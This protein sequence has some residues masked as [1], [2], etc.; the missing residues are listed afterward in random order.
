MKAKYR[1]KPMFRRKIRVRTPSRSHES[2]L[3]DFSRASTA[4]LELGNHPLTQVEQ[5]VLLRNY[6]VRIKAAFDE[7]KFVVQQFVGQLSSSGFACKIQDIVRSKLGIE[8]SS[9]VLSQFEQYSFD[10][11]R[12][13]C[14]CVFAQFMAMSEEFFEQDPL[15][16][17]N[18][19][20]AENMFR[21]AGF[22]AV[23]IAPCADGR[24]AHLISYV[25]RLPY[26]L[27]RRKAHAGAL[28]DVSESV[29]NWVFIEHSRFREGVPNSIDEPTRYL[30]IAV[31][32][33]SKSDPSHQ[34][35]AAHGSDDSKAAEAALSKL[36]DFR[37]AI[38]NRFGCGSTVQTLLI[39]MN[40]DDDSLKMHV[41]DK[42]GKVS[43]SRFVE[44]NA[45]F[46]QTIKMTA[47][48]ARVQ[49][50]QAVLQCNIKNGSTVALELMNEL[51]AWFIENNF[52][53]IEYVNQYEKGCY[54]DI[55]H[56][57]RFIGIGSGFEEVQIRNLTYYSYLDTVEEGFNDVDVGIKIFT[58]LNIKNGLPIPIVIRCDYDGR[59]P[60]SKERAE[61]KAKRIE[62]AVHN[63]YSDL[64]KQGKLQTL[65]TLRDNTGHQ[66]AE[67]L[68]G[69]LSSRH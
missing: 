4:Q 64:S 59:V 53:Q 47:E 15:K 68:V 1:K 16:G 14:E 29:R 56:A 5:N 3:S 32:H 42:E 26:S 46:H 35:C 27:V 39:G 69:L 40:T 19:A 52:S 6:E 34:G 33:Y 54:S 58:G 38:E 44:T 23:G 25:L 11:D 7:I 22:H 10:S 62:G 28:F 65:C 8:L 2:F 61:K 17:Q 57:E 48:Q 66:P 63:R 13:Y 51:I 50:Q 20:K 18:R 37:Q 55:G 45:L 67:R 31:Y 60:G 9:E 41:P 49:I 21:K 12:F 24:L 30:K 36:N 43:L